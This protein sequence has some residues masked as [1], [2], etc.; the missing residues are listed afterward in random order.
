MVRAVAAGR[1]TFG[2]VQRETRTACGFFVRSLRLL[3]FTAWGLAATCATP[4]AE[5]ATAAKAPDAWQVYLIFEKSCVGCHGGHLAKPK[6]KFGYVLDLPR[7]IKEAHIHP[8][9]PEKSDLFQALVSTDEEEKMPPP[10]SDGPMPTAAQIELIRTWIANGAVVDDTLASTET[11]TTPAAPAPPAE[12]PLGQKLGRLHPVL[13]HFPIALLLCATGTELLS[14]LMRANR[15][16]LQGAT[17]GSLWFA[18]FGALFTV[19]SGWLNAAHEGFATGDTDTH[20]WLGVATAACAVLALVVS[21]ITER[22]GGRNGTGRSRFVL[23]LVLLA[24]AVVVSLA[25]HTGGLLAYGKDY[26]SFF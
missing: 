26:F 20:R 19:G 3:G 1:R 5:P 8:H 23:L 18:A 24:G 10:D 6:G 21:E 15:G 22:A 13:V 4:A 14:R 12:H 2:F 17:R 25:G 16:W 9:E 11:A 7:L